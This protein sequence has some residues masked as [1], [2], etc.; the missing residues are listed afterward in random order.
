MRFSMTRVTPLLFATMAVTLTMSAALLADPVRLK[1]QDD[2]HGKK[3]KQLKPGNPGRHLGWEHQDWKTG[4]KEAGPSGRPGK[5]TSDRGV[6]EEE[7]G[8][9]DTSDV[10]HVEPLK[11]TPEPGTLALLA[12]GIAGAALAR[13]RRRNRA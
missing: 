6:G 12:T 8:A 10:I 13:R 3:A 1:S 7:S 5:D 4:C 2:C 9:G 11:V